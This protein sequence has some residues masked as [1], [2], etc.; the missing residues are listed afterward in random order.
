MLYVGAAKNIHNRIVRHRVVPY[1]RHTCIVFPCESYML[2]V[3][4]LQI[5]PVEAAYIA[6]YSPPHNVMSTATWNAARKW[7]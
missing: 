7:S 6:H 1:T 3:I 5:G 4:R 2:K